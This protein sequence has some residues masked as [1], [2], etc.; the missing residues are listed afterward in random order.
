[1]IYQKDKPG[2]NKKEDPVKEI[3]KVGQVFF[4]NAKV[5]VYC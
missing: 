3:S 2:G 4:H 5:G 1:M